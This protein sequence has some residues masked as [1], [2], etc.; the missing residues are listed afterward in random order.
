[1]NIKNFNCSKN[2]LNRLSKENFKLS[3]TSVVLAS[4]IMVGASGCG[5]S[6][7]NVENTPAPTP[8]AQVVEVIPTPTPVSTEEPLKLSAENIENVVSKKYDELK[9]ALDVRE[10]YLG[11]L[12]LG[13]NMNYLPKSEFSLIVGE[14]ADMEKF[15]LYFIQGYNM[16]KQYNVDCKANEYV[17][18]S[19]FCF[20]RIDSIV[21]GKLDETAIGLKK[22]FEEGTK[23]EQQKLIDEA[24]E[25]MNTLYVKG[26]SI[27]IDDEKH[28]E[29]ELSPGAGLLAETIGDMIS[30]IITNNTIVTK[31]QRAILEACDKVNDGSAFYPY[32][33]NYT[34]EPCEPV[35]TK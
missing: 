12:Y 21:L 2:L 10:D 19:E 24:L 17:S 5:Q 20:D 7:K 25:M 1:M 9:D 13:S 15:S 29:F 23:E 30:D 28:A 4:A 31:E 27:T 6:P 26:S 32:M 35:K 34:I 33:M 16:F 3:L 18:L 8:S 11:V 14:E 22:A